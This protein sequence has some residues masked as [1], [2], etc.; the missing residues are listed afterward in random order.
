MS[1]LHLPALHKTLVTSVVTPRGVIEGLLLEGIK[2]GTLQNSKWREFFGRSFRMLYE[3][4][5]TLPDFK[6][7]GR[8]ISAQFPEDTL[9]AL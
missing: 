7:L 1:H 3:F 8:Q 6:V 5:Y 2:Q 4:S 9:Q